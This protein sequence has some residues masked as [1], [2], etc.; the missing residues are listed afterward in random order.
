MSGQP[1][2]GFASFIQQLDVLAFQQIIDCKMEIVS[3]SVQQ[4]AAT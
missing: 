3:I 1:S 2:A 4:L